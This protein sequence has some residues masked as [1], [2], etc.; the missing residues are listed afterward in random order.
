MRR[1]LFAVTV[2]SLAFAPAPLPRRGGRADSDTAVSLA[3]LQGTWTITK[4]EQIKDT[5]RVD[6]GNY[7]KEIRV[8]SARWHFIYREAGNAPVVYALAVDGNKKPATF[9]L[10]VVGQDHPYGRGLIQR[11]GDEVKVLYGFDGKRPPTFTPL[12]TGFVLMTLRRQR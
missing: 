5:G 4:L 8:E 2:L 11:Q 12:P 1:L 3:L 7:L 10:M 6:M 9:D